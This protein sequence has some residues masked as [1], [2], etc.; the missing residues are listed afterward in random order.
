MIDQPPP[1]LVPI[2]RRVALIP[3]PPPKKV[4]TPEELR[5]KE[6]EAFQPGY[7]LQQKQAS[8]P[9]LGGQEQA[10]R[11]ARNL[12]LIKSLTLDQWVDKKKKKL[13]K[14]NVDFDIDKVLEPRLNRKDFILT[15]QEKKELQGGVS[16]TETTEEE[17]E[18]EEV[19]WPPPE[20]PLP[21]E[22][23]LN[24]SQY[25]VE[26]VEAD[27][28]WWQEELDRRVNSLGRKIRLVREIKANGEIDYEEKVITEEDIVEAA[29][30]YAE[31]KMIL[32]RVTGEGY[33]TYE[34]AEEAVR[35]E[36][37]KHRKKARKKLHDADDKLKNARKAFKKFQKGE[38]NQEAPEVP[39]LEPIDQRLKRVA[40][41]ADKLHEDYEKLKTEF[42]D[43]IGKDGESR[44]ILAALHRFKGDI[45]KA[46]KWLGTGQKKK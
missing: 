19:K 23:W 43:E 15:K 28:L 25:T 1:P 14:K 26:K 11:S 44:V 30:A 18:E 20:E 4:E 36:L 45:E 9:L 3:I 16:D 46:R 27:H 29:N 7:K 31:Q 42:P 41:K 2:K 5:E 12:D 22:S 35:K 33:P 6:L 8:R 24:P 10:A 40:E 21:G 38:D 39:G 17:P 37:K 13:L 32:A 34:Q